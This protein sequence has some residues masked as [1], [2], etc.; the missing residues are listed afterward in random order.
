M[1]PFLRMKYM[2]SSSKTTLAESSDLL[3]ES[4]R[5]GRFFDVA[6][7]SAN[8]P[9]FPP[10]ALGTRC[11]MHS[12]LHVRHCELW[13]RIPISGALHHPRTLVGP[14]GG[15]SEATLRLL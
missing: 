11:T 13:P 4:W 5:F 2:S 3:V 7:P 12:T 15:L 8:L 14:E 10:S 1:S 9:F 6:L